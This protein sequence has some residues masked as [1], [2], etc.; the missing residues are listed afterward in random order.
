MHQARK[1]QPQ[2]SN[3]D[4]GDNS[5]AGAG[6]AYI[7]TRDGNTWSQQAYLKASNSEAGDFFGSSTSI[8][9]NVVVVGA[10]SEASNATGVDGNSSD[11]SAKNAGA[12]YIFTSNNGIWS[13]QVYLKASNTE[14]YDFFGSSVAV[15]GNTVVVGAKNETSNATE[16]NGNQ[17]DNSAPNAG[18]AY[19]FNRSGNIWSQQ[20][21]LKSTNNSGGDSFGSTVAIAGDTVVIGALNDDGTIFLSSGAGGI[22]YVFN[23]SGTVWSQHAFFESSF[24]GHGESF[25]FSVA[26]ANNTVVVGSVGEK[27]HTGAAYAFRVFPPVSSQPIPTLSEWVMLLLSLI[28]GLLVWVKPSFVNWR[29]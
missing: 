26:I 12:A 25:G 3:G 28:L 8:S 23:R 11:N 7:F 19:V 27:F 6:A 17:S 5:A 24:I 18:A 21:Y 9:G 10:E 20:A 2:G 22:T 13:Q 4:Q 16:V 15:S 29:G 1:A 14:E